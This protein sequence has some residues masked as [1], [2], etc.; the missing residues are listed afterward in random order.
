MGQS[1]SQKKLAGR[2]RQQPPAVAQE[3]VA[4]MQAQGNSRRS[5]GTGS[6]IKERG[7]WYGQWRVGGRLVKRKLGPVREPGTREGLTRKQAETVLRRKMAEVSAPSPVRGKTIE[8]AGYAYID[9]LQLLGRKASTIQ[10]Y[11]IILNRHLVR[12]FRRKPID[13][14]DSE[15]V[16]ALVRARLRE[17]LAHSTVNHIL[18]VLGGTFRHAT[19]RGWTETDPVPNVD[20]PPGPQVN[21]DIRFLD[22]SEVGRLI[23][24]VPDNTLGRMERALYLTA[25]MTGLRQGELVALRWADVDWLAGVIRVR[26]NYTRREWGTPKSRRSSRAV[27]MPSQVAAELERHFQGSAHQADADLVFGHPETGNP[28]DASKLRKRFKTAL[29][30]AGVREVRFHDLRHTYATRM[31][32]AGTPMRTLQEYLGHRDSRTTS[33]YADY[34][35]D[36]TQGAV[37]TARAF[38][39]AWPSYGGTDPMS[40]SAAH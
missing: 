25:A 34:A 16:A 28:Y 21:P 39:D 6:I 26:R 31:A 19:K 33:I 1:R 23:A 40:L 24:A 27:P 18:N 29:A 12:H 9:H 30:H 3:V 20:R 7:S 8:E 15:D 37:F 2:L 4:P 13:R 32:A 22:M 17:G 11:R 10:D 35:P 5:Y 14:I 38:G 36:P